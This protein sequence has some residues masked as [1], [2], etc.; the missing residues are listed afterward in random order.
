MKRVI[1]IIAMFICSLSIVACAS[2]EAL[3]SKEFMARMK[4]EGH[5]VEDVTHMHEELDNIETVLIA[6]TGSYFVEFIVFA[7]EGY[8]RS[9][10]NRLI[11]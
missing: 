6:D 2:R 8:A 10:F 1:Y 9:G 3:S 4:S 11:P 5:L 7:N